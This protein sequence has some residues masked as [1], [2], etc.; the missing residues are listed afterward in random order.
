[1]AGAIA[2]LSA[3]KMFRYMTRTPDYY[4]YSAQVAGSG[5]DYYKMATQ[6]YGY[7]FV[8]IFSLLTVTHILG[9]MGSMVSL[10]YVITMAFNFWAF[11]LIHMIGGVLVMLAYDN[12]YTV[13]QDTTSSYQ[14][15]ALSLMSTIQMQATTLAMIETARY[16]I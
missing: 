13:S 2:T 1:M 15:T 3:L 12:A 8:G 9:W 4:T 16:L 6:Y 5:T 11:P 7:T 10:D 14:A